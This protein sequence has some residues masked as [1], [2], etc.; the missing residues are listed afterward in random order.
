MLGILG[1]VSIFIFAYNA[2]KTAQGNGR[3]AVGW[4]LAVFG[5][6][7]GLQIIV[8]FMFGIIIAV[9]MISGGSTEAQ[10][11]E[12]IY[13]PAVVMGVIS[14][15]LS[16]AGMFLIVRHVGKIPEDTG[17]FSPPPPPSE[18]SLK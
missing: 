11:Q 14:T 9:V 7:L 4:T 10:V 2:Y 18:F 13:G 15:I 17:E 12:S 5:V 3:N 16:I 1:F 8:P 6:G